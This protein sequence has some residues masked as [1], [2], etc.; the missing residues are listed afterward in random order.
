MIWKTKTAYFTSRNAFESHIT[1]K[2]NEKSWNPNMTIPQQDILAKRKPQK[3]SREISTGQIWRRQS[4]NTYEL[5]TPVN[6]T[7]HEGT[8]SMDSY[9]PSR[10]LTLRGNPFPWISLWH[11][12]SRRGKPK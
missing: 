4:T 5:A 1:T 12:Q 3:L 8:Q 7:S 11:F 2:S 10:Y 6:E 9:N